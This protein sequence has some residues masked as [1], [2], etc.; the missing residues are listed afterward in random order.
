MRGITKSP[1]EAA[2]EAAEAEK[3]KQTTESARYPHE[4]E[5]NE[6]KSD[7][8]ENRMGDN[9]HEAHKSEQ[10]GA[11]ERDVPDRTLMAQNIPAR[12][13]STDRAGERGGMTL[14]IV[15]EAG[16]GSSTGARS[17]RSDS[18]Q[19]D[20][21]PPTPPKDAQDGHLSPI[22][23]MLQP[24]AVPPKE[25][26]LRSR[27]SLQSTRSLDSNKALPML[28]KE[29]LQDGEQ[30]RMEVPVKA[31]Q[32]N[33]YG[34]YEAQVPQSQPQPQTLA[35]PPIRQML[36]PRRSEERRVGKECPV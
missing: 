30:R 1:E 36:P 34:Q 10:R 19:G 28:P 15:E 31:A 22:G 33:E 4:N 35:V 5:S 6:S 8:V 25:P 2:R 21:P 14:P 18:G 3:S 20:R 17:N 12:A 26:S 9:E 13:P 32:M 29:R 16:E 7:P 27:S 24:P 11:S 23:R